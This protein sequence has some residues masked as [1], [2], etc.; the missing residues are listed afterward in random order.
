M[1]KNSSLEPLCYFK[2]TVPQKVCEI[3]T[4]ND[5][6]GPNN[7]CRQFFLNFKIARL[8]DTILQQGDCRCK[9]D[10]S[11]LEDSAKSR[12]QNGQRG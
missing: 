8:E 3:I 9:T 5:R 2:G 10:V 1:I 12:H 11:D 7:V 6:L 4:L